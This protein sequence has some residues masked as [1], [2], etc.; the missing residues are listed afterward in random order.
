MKHLGEQARTTYQNLNSVD[1]KT[2]PTVLDTDGDGM[3]MVGKSSTV[4]GLAI[5]SMEEITG[6]SIQPCRVDAAWDADQDG[7]ANLCEYQ[8]SL[9]RDAGLNGDLLEE[10]GE[11]P[12]SVA[13]W[14]IPDPNLVDSDGDTLPDG[15]EAE[16]QCTWSPLRIGVNPLN[17]SDMFEN[18]DGDGYDVNKDG[19]LTPNEMFVNYLEY[20]I[21]SGLFLNNQS[22]DGTELPNGYN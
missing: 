4:D 11:S 1:V 16:R 20:H 2:D 21:R 15:W 17:G 8:W 5:R 14:S 19:V 12:E 6:R 10:F 9:V 22:L 13:L 18:P 7:L 3:P